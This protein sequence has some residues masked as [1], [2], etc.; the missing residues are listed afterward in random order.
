MTQQT[1]LDC[2]LRYLEITCSNRKGRL[3]IEAGA[4][5]LA[6][7]SYAACAARFDQIS[8]RESIEQLM[9]AYRTLT[10]TE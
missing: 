3:T 10:H 8:V 1:A 6:Q 9:Q 7:A 4:N 2:D 5:T